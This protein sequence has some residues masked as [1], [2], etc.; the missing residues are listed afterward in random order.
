MQTALRQLFLD[1]LSA[2][3]FLTL[4]ALT[5]NLWLATGVA[6]GVS[7]AQVVIAKVRGERIDAMQ[8]LVLFLVLV[9][10]GATL[11]AN[12]AR[13]IMVK[14]S[15]IHTAIGIVMLRPGW[16]GRY[17]P[18]IAKDNLSQRFIVGAGYCWAAWFF[19]L[20]A[21]N[22]VVAM[23]FDFQVR[24]WFFAIGLVGGKIL[25]VIMQYAVGRTVVVRKLRAAASQ[26][27]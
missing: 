16:M 11:I 24:S 25:A 10:G 8:W 23:N 6:V 9:L 22:L 27:A 2:I 21:A 15:I 17:L 7:I 26:A 13:F 12:D 14:P 20:A 3:V 5:D 19:V 4:Y 18:P 1:F